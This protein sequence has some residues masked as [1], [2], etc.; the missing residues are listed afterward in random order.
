M[1]AAQ[2]HDGDQQTEGVGDDEPLPTV[3][4]L[5]RVVAAAVPADG[6]GTLHRLGVHQSGAG[7]GI[8]TLGDPELFA[9]RSEDLLGDL[10][11]LP[12]GEVPV[13]RL[14]RREVLWQLPPRTAG[15]HHVQ[16]AVD[17]QPARVLL[18]TPTGLRRRQQRLDQLPLLIGQVRGIPLAPCQARRLPSCHRSTVDRPTEI[19]TQTHRPISNTLLAEFIDPR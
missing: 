18:R 15:A 8:A 5:P 7:P 9:D 11:V 1:L 17:D 6:V 13:H 19:I 16:D 3:D 4:L 14:P 10:G 12:A 2:T